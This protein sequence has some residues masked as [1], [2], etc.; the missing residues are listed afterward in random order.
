[1]N[2]RPYFFEIFALANFILIQALLWPMRAPLATLP[3][4]LWT[5]GLGFLGQVAVGVAIRAIVAWRRGELRSYLAIIRSSHWIADTLRLGLASALFVHAYA[6]IKLAIPLLHPRLFDQTLWDLDRKLL[7]GHSPNEF[8]LALFSAPP[9]LR[10][11]DWSYANVFLASLII[12][13]VFFGSAP[14]R[15]LR[16]AF[17]NSNVVLWLAGAW[18]YVAVP[19]LGPAFAFPNVWQPLSALLDRTQ[20]LQRLLMTNYR[21]LMLLAH[22]VRRPISLFFGVA[23]FPSLHVAF[24]TLVF[25]WMRRTW[26]GGQVIFGVFVVAILI[27]SIVTGWHYLIDGIAG[28]ALACLCYWLFAIRFA[29]RTF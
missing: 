11:I 9:V 29:P 5:V 17:M 7:A 13:T 15:Q 12:A 1:M 26:R 3:R 4:G 10:T 19:S 18:L 22:G 2:K 8:F 28:I 23:A 25:L 27:G 24:Q 20:T 21:N 16:V 14:N 6:W